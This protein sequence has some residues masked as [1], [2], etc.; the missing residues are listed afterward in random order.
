MLF[1]NI[2]VPGF[3]EL[4]WKENKQQDEQEYDLTDNAVNM[5]LFEYSVKILR[6]PS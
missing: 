2:C 3:E 6:W 1:V 4:L 5:D